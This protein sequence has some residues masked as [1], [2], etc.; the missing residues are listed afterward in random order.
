MNNCNIFMELG[1]LKSV[2]ETVGMC[3]ESSST[4]HIKRYLKS[5]K[6]LQINSIFCVNSEHEQMNFIRHQ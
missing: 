3:P 6:V 4:L 5:T 2:V 1:I